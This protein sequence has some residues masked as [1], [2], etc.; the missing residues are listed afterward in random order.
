MFNL[1]SGELFVVVFITVA[2]VS[3]PWWLRLGELVALL[4]AGHRQTSRDSASGV[5]PGSGEPE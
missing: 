5:P 2:V 1:T 4:L 3:A